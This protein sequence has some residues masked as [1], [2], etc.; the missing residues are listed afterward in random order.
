LIFVSLRDTR[1]SSTDDQ[2]I[3]Q[4]EVN[5]MN[6][7]VKILLLIMILLLAAACSSE[8]KQTQ[9]V[10][11]KTDS[12]TSTAPPSKEAQQRENALVR[13]INTVP[14]SMSFD[15]FA[16]DQKVFASV[17]FKN[18]TPYKE[19][20]DGRLSFRVR[21][22]G[23]DSAQPVAENN[24]DL[25]G[26]KHYTIVVMPGTND[27]TTVDLVNDNITG[28]PAEK[29]LVRVIHASPDA[30]EIDILDKQANKK[31]FS[32]LHFEKGTSYMNVDP[33][34][35]TLEMRQ[36]GQ[37]KAIVTLPN[38]NFEKGKFY[39]IIVTG[40]ARGTPKLET[41]MVEDQLGGAPTASSPVPVSKTKT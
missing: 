27:K 3:I 7:L 41:L 9:P 11:T 23:H 21:Q 2:A 17:A 29:A 24:K 36:E 1:T 18:V 19:L 33:K 40:Y 37:D 15:I 4:E 14:G 35:T 8:P 38:A 10:T 31:L 28:P 32:S 13:V 12:G 16:D 34:R 30:G 5:F 39:T 20:S 26:G 25:I 22:A 6:K